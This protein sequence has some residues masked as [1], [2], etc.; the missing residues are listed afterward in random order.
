MRYGEEELL[1]IWGGGPVRYKRVDPSVGLAVDG[2]AAEFAQAKRKR[3]VSEKTGIF[4]VLFQ[5]S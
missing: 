1:V 2:R 3:D 4:A 5:R